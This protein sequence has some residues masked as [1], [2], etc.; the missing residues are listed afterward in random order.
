MSG[1]NGERQ[2][3]PAKSVALTGRISR[4]KHDV[5]LAGEKP[6]DNILSGRQQRLILIVLLDG[7]L[8]LDDILIRNIINLHLDCLLICHLQ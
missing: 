1:R 7:I 5:I 6:G 3:I 2:R 4:V 8:F